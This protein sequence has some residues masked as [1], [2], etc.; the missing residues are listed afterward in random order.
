M[1]NKETLQLV[2]DN[3]ILAATRAIAVD[4]G[5]DVAALPEGVR[6]QNLEQFKP[7]RDRFRGALNTHS[8]K[9]FSAYAT[10]HP[11]EGP[12]GFIDQDR[13][14]ATVIFNL[15]DP[16][17]PGHGDDVAHLTLKA[18]A[19]YAALCQICGQK[20]TQQALAEWLED[21]SSNLQAFACEQVL[22]VPQAIAAVRRMT[23][24]ATSQRDSVVGD[25]SASR[26]AMDEIEAKSQEV[27]PTHFLF[28]TEPFEGLPVA[29]ITLRL[30]VITG[31]DS[32]MLKLRWS[33]EE[34]QRE[35]FAKN[36]KQTLSAEIGGLIPLTIGTF[37]IAN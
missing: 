18:T 34:A 32:P 29:V 5:A 4:G 10:N 24:K 3:A 36:F 16:N 30:S 15:G 26:S 28:T 7:H 25:F 2:I 27:L 1:L 35:E 19:A 12:A 9:D 23:I 8:I 6:L 31:G 22:S 14:R 17:S 11:H 20:L 21:W 33:Q 37:A 13:M